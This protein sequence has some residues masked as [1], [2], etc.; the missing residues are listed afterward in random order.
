MTDPDWTNYEYQIRWALRGG[1]TVAV[2]ANENQWIKGSDAAISLSP[3]FEKRVVEIEADRALFQDRGIATGLVEFATI[4]AGKPRVLKRTTLRATDTTPTAKLALYH[5]KG[6]QIAYRVTWH[7]KNGSKE[8]K[9][10]VLDS[11][12]LYLTPPESGGTAAGAPG[13]GQ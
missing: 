3:P 11:D 9:L 13:A 12:Y 6:T 2:P 7:S 1:P 4:L 5:D 8:G 10:E